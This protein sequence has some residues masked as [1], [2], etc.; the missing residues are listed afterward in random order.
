LIKSVAWIFTLI[1]LRTSSSSTNLPPHS[2]APRTLSLL[3]RILSFRILLSTMP[4]FTSIND[5]DANNSNQA[6]EELDMRD[7]NDK[8]F[9]AV[10]HAMA[11][12]TKPLD[13]VP[14]E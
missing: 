7:V 2:T 12:P 5:I 8:E 11:A 14:K 1:D 3:F 4:V 9:D 13:S 10:E 6:V